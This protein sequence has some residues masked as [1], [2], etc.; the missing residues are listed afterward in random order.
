MLKTIRH[1]LGRRWNALK[2]A[3]FQYQILSKHFGSSEKSKSQEK[4]RA[5]LLME[6][7]VIEK[8]LSLKDIRLGFGQPKVTHVLELTIQYLKKYNDYSILNYVLT[9]IKEY[10]DFHQSNDFAVSEIISNNYKMLL[11]KDALN[12]KKYGGGTVTVTKK[13]IVE[14]SNID[15]ER[16]S[17]NRFSIRNFTGNDVPKEKIFKALQIAQKTPSPCNRQPWKNYVIF[18]KDLIDQVITLQQGGR[19]FKNDLSCIILVTSGYTH[20]FGSENYQPHVSGGMYSMSLIY[21]LHSLGLGTI[22]LNLGIDKSRL[23]QIHTLLNISFENAPILIIGIGEISDE[24]K[25]AYAERFD[26]QDYTTIYN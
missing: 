10:L 21:A 20:F 13:D 16:F 11:E 14:A 24:L 7:H 5:F 23:K 6:L 2:L 12:N 19:Q 17:K 1:Q 25:V 26:Y 18:N 15:F 22:P 4:E 9:P 8:G 3:T